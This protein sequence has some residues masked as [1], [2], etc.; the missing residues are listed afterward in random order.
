MI[1]PMLQTQMGFIHRRF[2]LGAG[3]DWSWKPCNPPLRPRWLPPWHVAS[4]ETCAYLGGGRAEPGGNAQ[5]N[6]NLLHFVYQLLICAN[7]NMVLHMCWCIF[8]DPQFP[9]QGV[10]ESPPL[11]VEGF[12][13]WIDPF[14]RC[15]ILRAGRM[16]KFAVWE[17]GDLENREKQLKS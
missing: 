3:Y 16:R 15:R 10:C 5:R 4:A 7:I 6:G 17:A 1:Y 11:F 8:A 14:N 2:G 12:W 9:D 13:Q